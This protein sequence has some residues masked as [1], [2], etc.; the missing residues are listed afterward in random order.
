MLLK[1][2]LRSTDVDTYYIQL[3]N[4]RLAEWYYL[5]KLSKRYPG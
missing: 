5:V 1:I 2:V 3:Q 4:I